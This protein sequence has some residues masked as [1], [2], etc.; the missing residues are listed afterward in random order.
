MSKSG[1]AANDVRVGVVQK[2]YWFCLNCRFFKPPI[3]DKNTGRCTNGHG[4]QYRE[5]GRD[6]ADFELPARLERG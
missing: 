1:Y 6:C 3:H 5:D 2:E 4:R